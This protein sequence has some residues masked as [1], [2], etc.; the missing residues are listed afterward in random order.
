MDDGENCPTVWM[1]LVPLSCTV[2]YGENSMFY[3]TFTT[4]KSFFN[5]KKIKRAQRTDRSRFLFS[6]VDVSFALTTWPHPTSECL[7]SALRNQLIHKIQCVSKNPRPGTVVETHKKGLLF[8]HGLAHFVVVQDYCSTPQI[9][10]CQ[11]SLSFT[12]SRSLLILMSI[13]SMMPS[14]HR[15]LCHPLLLL[16]S[17]FPSSRVF[18]NE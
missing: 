7:H 16:P 1:Y 13:E 12:I 3:A 17:V 9:T 18:S 5:L 10:A 8:L 6:V 15:I 2:K 11:V 14:N 4:V